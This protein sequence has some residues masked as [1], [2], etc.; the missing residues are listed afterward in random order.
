MTL[1]ALLA[2]CNTENDLAGIRI[3]SVAVVLGDFDHMS[4]TITGL[5]VESTPYDGFIVQATYEPEEDRTKKG[6]MAAQLEGLLGDVDDKGRLDLYQY[7]AVYLNSGTRGFALGQ[8]N[9]LLLPDDAVLGNAEYVDH[10]CTYVESGGTLVVSDWAWEAVERCWPDAVEFAGDDA[11]TD[12]AQL[13]VAD[14]G[15]TATVVDTDLA[16]VL[17][18]TVAIEYDYSAWAVIEAE[19]EG[20]E[21]LLSG[22]VEYQPSSDSDYETLSDVPLM[23]RFGA[24]TGQV[25]FSTFHVASQTKFVG[26]GLVAYGVKGMDALVGET[27]E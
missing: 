27:A 13:G 15:V 10:L 1:L 25:V 3:D 23:V 7:G 24:G 8:Y 5:D 19:G 21:V 20:T 6:E 4:T 2:A 12:G 11:A 17:G 9:N 26:E 16:A 14:D 22:T 18:N